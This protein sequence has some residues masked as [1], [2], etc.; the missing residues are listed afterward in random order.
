M[1]KFQLI[2]LN[3]YVLLSFF[4]LKILCSL[5]QYILTTVS[6]PSTSSSFPSNSLLSWIHIPSVS[7][8]KRVDLQETTIKRQ[9]LVKSDRAKVLTL[10]LDRHPNRRKK[11]PETGKRVSLLTQSYFPKS[12]QNTKLTFTTQIQATCTDLLGPAVPFQ[13]L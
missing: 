2:P 10:K 1:E 11:F 3:F 13:S 12:H 5:K 7:H 4:S 6:P 9:N 8:Q